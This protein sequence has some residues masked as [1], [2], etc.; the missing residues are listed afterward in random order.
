MQPPQ[1]SENNRLEYL[2]AV[3]LE[4]FS[5][6]VTPSLVSKISNFR[7]HLK[8]NT[9]IFITHLPGSEFENVIETAQQLYEQ[10]FNPVP[11][12][13]ARSIRNKQTLQRHL[14]KLKQV[15]RLEEVLLIGGSVDNPVGEFSDTMQLLDTGLFES[16]DI[17]RIGVAG[18][19]EGSPDI[20]DDAIHDALKW[21]N[22][23]AVK[24]SI[25]LHLVTQFCFEA[26]P[27]INWIERIGVQGNRLSVCVGIPGLA[28]IK[29]LLN[30]ARAC[31]VGPSM[32]FISR[33]ARNVTKILSV[34][35][36]DKLIIDLA[37]YCH[38]QPNPGIRGIHV[39]SLG[40]FKKSSTWSNAVARRQITLN[41]EGDGF[42][43]NM[44]GN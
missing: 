30:H 33:Q 20:S 15:A 14:D 39:F 21:K 1:L 18:H 5:I 35:S 2:I 25:N 7:E 10:G 8:P 19:P 40:A 26:K 11:H 4:D 37:K 27:V 36:P 12:L 32:R 13:A 24:T 41:S 38:N 44:S 28:T 22:D 34:S 3:M 9:S 43:T 17:S 31:G 23:F 6:E 42:T 16:F 29:S